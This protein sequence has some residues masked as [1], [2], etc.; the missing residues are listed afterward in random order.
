ME[1]IKELGGRGVREEYERG[2]K[3]SK[4]EGKVEKLEGEIGGLTDEGNINEGDKDG[5]KEGERVRGA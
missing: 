1:H 4:G 5:G 3:G 2:G